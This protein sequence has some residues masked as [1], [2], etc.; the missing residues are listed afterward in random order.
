M[1]I[2]S[3]D[4]WKK[5]W[6]VLIASFSGFSDDN[7]LKLSASLAYYTVFSLAPLLIMILSIIGI[8]FREDA[9]KNQIYPEIIGYVGSDAAMQIQNMVKALTLSGKSGIALISG[10]ITLILG[11]TSMFLEIQD[12]INMIWRVKAKPKRGWVK[13][14]K[15]RFL[16]FSMI[17]SLGFLLLVSLLLNVAVNAF[18]KQLLKYLPDVTVWVFNGINV[19]IA[20]VVISTLFGIIFKFLP[21]VNIKWRDVRSGAI[22]TAIL[23]LIGKYVIG[24]YIEYTAQGSAYGAA[25]S[26]IVILVW[27]YYTA[28]ILY[29]GAEFTQAYAEASGS[30]IKP[31][32]YAVHVKQ[33]EVEEDRKVLPAQHPEIEGALK[34]EEEKGKKS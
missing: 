7:G 22:F 18:S 1:R 34:E 20:F 6:K 32:E 14:L 10:V 2:L 33:T 15:N 13:M 27:I 23:F 5:I 26:I 4:F 16:S 9:F 12:S 25:G 29:I 17:I 31:A 24:L 3:K 28:A 30:D 11:A 21:D 19:A 8:V